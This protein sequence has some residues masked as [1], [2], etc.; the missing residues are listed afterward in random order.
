MLR[1][2]PVALISLTTGLLL[3]AFAH[4]PLRGFV[5]DVLVVVFLD[6]ALATLS[7]GSARTRLPFVA[8]LSVGLEGL[9]ALHLVDKEA[10]ALLHLLL[11]STF[12]PWDLLA[13]ALGLLPAVALER[14]WATGKGGSAQTGSPVSAES[15]AS[16]GPST[17]A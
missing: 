17:G 15:S 12:D 1:P 7:L 6:A 10:P 16:R 11:G 3:F 13:Y 8:A 9:Q 4:G 5:G 2:L 14:R